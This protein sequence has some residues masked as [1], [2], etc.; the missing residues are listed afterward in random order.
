MCALPHSFRGQTCA[1]ECNQCQLGEFG[2]CV[3]RQGRGAEDAVG[4]A[5]VDNGSIGADGE[6]RVSQALDDG[7]NPSRRTPG[8]Q[9]ERRAGFDDGMHGGAGAGTDQ[10]VVIDEGAVDIGRNQGWAVRADTTVWAHTA[11]VP[12]RYDG[13]AQRARFGHRE[14][15]R[16]SRKT[17]FSPTGLVSIAGEQDFHKGRNTHVRA[18]RS[19]PAALWKLPA[20][21]EFPALWQLTAPI[22]GAFA[23]TAT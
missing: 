7:R 21:R 2:E 15:A 20:L 9:Q 14:T 18:A 8:C 4:V 19:A 17:H 13:L 5:V 12:A 1:R 23:A 6:W 11:I 22:P 10:L 3:D 16:D